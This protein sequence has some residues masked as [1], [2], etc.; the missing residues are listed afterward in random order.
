MEREFR[1][2]RRAI[3][4]AVEDHVAK[5]PPSRPG[6]PT[7]IEQRSPILF[8]GSWSVRL[9]GGGRHIDHLHPAGWLSSALYISLPSED[10]RGAGEAG[11]VGHRRARGPVAPPPPIHL[12]PAQH[13]PL[14][15]FPFPQLLR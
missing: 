7:L 4:E 11:W 10:E 9:T 3:V 1:Q 6:R 2:L 14:P 12:G 15:P 13:G 8:N 5:L